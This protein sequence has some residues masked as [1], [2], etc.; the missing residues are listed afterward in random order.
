MVD[1]GREPPLPPSP[2]VA[3]VREAVAGRRPLL[4]PGDHLLV[5][6]SGGPDS[7]A[8]L[9]ALALLRA[10][11][12]LRLTVCH[13][14]HGLRPEADRDAAFVEAL[15]ARLGCPAHVV[16]VELPRGGGRSPEEAARLA[17]H[18]ALARVARAT[19][20]SRIALGHTAD[21]Q[22]ETVLMRILEGAGP[23]RHPG[24][25]GPDRATAARRR[26]HD[27]PGSPRGPRAR[28]RGGRDEP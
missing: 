10:E 19:G 22:V 9:H 16:R 26:P 25:P 15:A 27:G 20:A 5:G 21:D 11:Y 28:G 14:H 17:R 6:V 8:L 13:V 18:A 7:V 23:R 1:D 3:A 24:A 2:L 4:D 12:T